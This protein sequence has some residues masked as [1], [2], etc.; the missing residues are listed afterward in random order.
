VHEK[1]VAEGRGVISTARMTSIAT[2]EA[3][4]TSNK[5]STRRR[6][7]KNRQPQSIGGFKLVLTTILVSAPSFA[8]CQ[9]QAAGEP[10]IAVGE[11]PQDLS[12]WGIFQHADT[13]V[14]AV[15]RPGAGFARHLDDLGR[16]EH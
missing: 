10:S 2:A 3:A 1:N 11:L 12:A 7:R 4:S 15:D 8:F 13:V 6:R 14:K 5:L 16:K 9:N